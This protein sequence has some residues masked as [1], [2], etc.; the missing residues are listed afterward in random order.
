MS[1]V[2]PVKFT[3]VTAKRISL[4]FI[5][6]LGVEDAAARALLK[7]GTSGC[8]TGIKSSKAI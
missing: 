3:T 7:R 8:P 2:Y 1:Y 6:P 5:P 4:G